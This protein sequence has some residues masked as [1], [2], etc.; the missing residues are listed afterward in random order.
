[1]AGEDVGGFEHCNRIV[2]LVMAKDAVCKVKPCSFN[3][4]YQ[5]NIL[6]TFPSGGILALSYFYD[7]IF[8]LLPAQGSAHPVSGRA[9]GWSGKPNGNGNG[10][11]KSVKSASSEPS[12]LPI[13]DVAL[14]ADR[15]CEGP[16]SWKEH[17]GP[18]SPFAQSFSAKGSTKTPEEASKEILAELD[19]RPEYCL[20]LTFMHALLRLGYEFGS[21]R[22]VRVE[23]KVDGV[24]LGWCLGAVIAMLLEEG[25]EGVQ[26]VA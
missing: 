22:N 12:S 19:D 26:C 20:D 25:G 13:S 21:E 6:N 23:K 10:N 18:S 1:M 15:V 3:G 9:W 5:P 11:T 14:L 8:Q 24:E 7:R 4:V 2:E 16:E 17:W